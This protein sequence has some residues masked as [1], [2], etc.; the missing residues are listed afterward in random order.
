[1]L[2]EPKEIKLTTKR[3]REE[4]YKTLTEAS[5]AAREL[6]I[7]TA[8]EYFSRYSED[9]ML[10]YNPS[11]YFEGWTSWMSFLGTEPYSSLEKA[12]EAAIALGIGSSTE[13]ATKYKLDPRL[14]SN[15]SKH[16][17]YKDAWSGWAEFLGRKKGS[18]VTHVTRNF[19]PTIEEAGEAALRLGID[20]YRDYKLK[21]KQDPRLH[22]N[23]NVF[24]AGTWSSWVSFLNL[25]GLDKAA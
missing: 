2:A 5:N 23:P 18:A 11:L 6:G 1:M 12:S 14:V 4:T 16:K 8:P 15:P 7:K 17:L 21:Y 22:S 13:Y 24:Y 10:P 20:G 25:N 9:P 19:Y 3:T